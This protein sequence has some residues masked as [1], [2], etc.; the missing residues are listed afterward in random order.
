MN[1]KARYYRHIDKNTIEET[2][3][4]RTIHLAFSEEG[5]V[6]IDFTKT[7]LNYYF[8]PMTIVTLKKLENELNC[9]L[10]KNEKEGIKGNIKVTQDLFYSCYEGI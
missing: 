9:I 8:E 4:K 10:A 6:T 2:L 7:L 1:V 3:S 5:F